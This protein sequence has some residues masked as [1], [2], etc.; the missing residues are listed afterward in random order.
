MTSGPILLNILLLFRRKSRSQRWPLSSQ[1]TPDEPPIEIAPESTTG[2]GA[3]TTGVGVGAGVG[4]AATIGVGV[5]GSEEPM[6]LQP[7][8]WVLNQPRNL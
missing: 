2:V 4:A 5:A 6:P 8:D 3:A 7:P 1:L